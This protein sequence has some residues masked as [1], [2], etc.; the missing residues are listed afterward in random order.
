MARN[1]SL[2]SIVAFTLTALVLAGCSGEQAGGGDAGQAFPPALVTVISVKPETVTIADELPGR[3]AAFRTA[4]I[5]AQVGGIIEKRLFE[6]G[7]E[8]E[9][10]QELFQIN[11]E[12]FKADADSA[13][14]A[15]QR[16]EAGLIRSQAKFDRAKQLVESKAISRD[17]YDDAVADLAQAKANVAEARAT[18]FGVSAFGTDLGLRIREGLGLVA[19]T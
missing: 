10:G 12:P 16:A 11:P 8:V 3:V 6:Q 9:A 7:S 18:L 1:S 17:A 2:A 14:A 19:V 4:E 13:A 15:L 5:R